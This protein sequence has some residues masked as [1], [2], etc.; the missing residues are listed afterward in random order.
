MKDID[1]LPGRYRERTAQ[2]RARLWRALM[3]CCLAGFVA[4]VALAQHAVRCSLDRQ[5]AA[6]DTRYPAA[7]AAAARAEHLQNDAAEIDAFAALYT[8]LEHPWPTTQLLNRVAAALPDSVVISEIKLETRPLP[9]TAPPAATPPVTNQPP[10]VA[11]AAKR[12]LDRLRASCDNLARTLQIS[13]RTTNAPQLHAFVRRLTPSPLFKDA[14]L[15]SLEAIK[16]DDRVTES[17]FELRLTLRTG[18]GQ[19]GGP[20]QPIL[21]L[22]SP[23]LAALSA[24]QPIEP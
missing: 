5:L 24:I 2:R 17:K 19:P 20:T 9:S 7:L 12:D 14:K 13:G 6:I 10:T 3:V 21:E 15:E 23:E 18:F 22:P 8:Y 11:D 1:F 16:S 4:A